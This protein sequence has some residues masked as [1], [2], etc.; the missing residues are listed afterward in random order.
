MGFCAKAVQETHFE[1]LVLCDLFSDTQ[2][3]DYRA[4]A[5]DIDLDQ[6]V[7]QSASFTDEAFKR[8]L[9]AEVFLILFQMLGQM[10]DTIGEQRDLTFG[11]AGV[12]FRF[13]SSVFGE[14]F[15]FFR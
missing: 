1:I 10:V 3:F 2:L 9:G 6:I 4:V 13:C 5:R 14:E 12:S 11:R 15:F 8:S 7:E